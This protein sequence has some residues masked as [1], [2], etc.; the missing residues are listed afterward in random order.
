MGSRSRIRPTRIWSCSRVEQSKRD[1]NGPV[2]TERLGRSSRRTR[3]SE[4]S[5]RV[6]LS[7]IEQIPK[8]WLEGC[9]ESLRLS[10]SALRFVE[11]AHPVAAFQE[12]AG[13]R[14]VGWT[15]DSVFLHQID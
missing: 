3:L 7:K 13:A 4:Q 10:W 1:D 11:F 14:A 5:R 6:E 15:D 8:A 9:G 2:V 12:L